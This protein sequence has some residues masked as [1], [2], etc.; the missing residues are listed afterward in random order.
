MNLLR[1]IVLPPL[2]LV[3]M[4]LAVANRQRV[5]F[6]LDPFNPTEPALGLDMPLAA[7]VLVA[8]FIGI[9][10]GGFAAWSQAK[11]KAARRAEPILPPASGPAGGAEPR[12]PAR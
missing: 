11:I 6:S 2:A 10:I 7:I 9:L 1:W 4:A 3:V 8:L 5:T 12:L